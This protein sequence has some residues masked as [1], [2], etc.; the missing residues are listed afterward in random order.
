MIK[1]TMQ[2]CVCSR[3]TVL[4]HWSGQ[5]LSSSWHSPEEPLIESLQSIF[6]LSKHPGNSG[7]LNFSL[8]LFLLL[9]RKVSWGIEGRQMPIGNPQASIPLCYVWFLK[10]TI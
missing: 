3:D 5:W 2:E 1:Y 7:L 8:S 10:C 4:A 6:V 9:T